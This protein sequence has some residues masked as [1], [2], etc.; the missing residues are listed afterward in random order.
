MRTLLAMAALSLSF[1]P[2]LASAQSIKAMSYN[3]LYEL[4]GD[5]EFH[6]NDP[7]P[8]TRTPHAPN[9]RWEN[10]KYNLFHQ[11]DGHDPDLIAFQEMFDVGWD[12]G[13]ADVIR[14]VRSHFHAE[15]GEHYPWRNRSVPDAVD[16]PSQS[17]NIGMHKKERMR[18]W[19]FFRKSRFEEKDAGE[20]CI[21]GTEDDPRTPDV[22][23]DDRP[24]VVWV[25][26]LDKSVRRELVVLNLHMTAGK[27]DD[28]PAAQARN[29]ETTRLLEALRT[30]PSIQG[31]PIVL[32]GDFNLAP[33]NRADPE[34]C[35]APNDA[36]KPCVRRTAFDCLVTYTRTTIREKV[37]AEDADSFCRLSGAF[38][39]VLAADGQAVTSRTVDFI[40]ASTDFKVQSA[41]T[42][43][44]RYYD[45][46]LDRNLDGIRTCSELP[47]LVWPPA[48]SPWVPRCT[49]S[50][51]CDC[52][53]QPI[54]ASDHNPV[55]GELLL[56]P[57]S[58][59]ASVK[60]GPR[61]FELE[62]QGHSVFSP[63]TRPFLCGMSQ[64]NGGKVGLIDSAMIANPADRDAIVEGLLEYLVSPRGEV[65]VHAYPNAPPLTGCL[66][67]S[68]SFQ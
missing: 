25:K 57:K 53:S 67:E 24:L 46:R 14:E 51:A 63:N 3:I 4:H 21:D 7:N 54:N 68:I 32:M 40:F 42:D 10:R 22:D 26:L 29:G 27:G 12:P 58:K 59:L 34:E 15:Y 36:T 31:K 47:P 11:V 52:Q 60:V 37:D 55:V 49:P 23:C 13:T 9:R 65:V 18:N 64:A 48:V 66:V 43:R 62:L 61:G 33:H 20:F 1:V 41:M 38:K 35:P 50:S 5:I 8:L 17:T 39:D 6:P 44:T 56:P 45:F 2:G 28:L 30:I 19:I 16:V